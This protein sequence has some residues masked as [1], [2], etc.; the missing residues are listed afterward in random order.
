MAGLSDRLKAL[1]VRIG[2][3]DLPKPAPR[4]TYPVEEMVQ[5]RFEISP[6][7]QTFVAEAEH[8][9]GARHGRVSL[10][11][12]TSLNGI[13][14]WMPDS[15]LAAGEPSGI[16]FLDTET[17]GLGRG[18]GTYAFLVGLGRY[19][20]R[21]LYVTQLFMRDPAEELAL[22]TTL[23]TYLAGES[24]TLVTFNGLGF[25]VPLLNVRYVTNAEPSPLPLMGHLDLLP[26]ARR[27]WSERLSSRS[28]SSLE[29]HILGFSRTQDDVPGWMIPQ[30]YFDYLRTGDARPLTNVFYHNAMDILS[31]AALLT[32]VTALLQEPLSEHVDGRDLVALGRLCEAQRRAEAAIQ[33]YQCGIAHKRNSNWEEAIALWKIAAAQG[34]TYAHIELAKFYEHKERSY[35]EAIRWTEAAIE[36]VSSQSSS[37]D[38]R[39]QQLAELEHRLNRL[40]GKLSRRG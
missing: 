27:L 23:D 31:M 17:T 18:T 11:S 9:L 35:G 29:Q 4:S 16:V 33:L 39:D 20:P 26:L 37:G 8:P 10:G 34:R 30:L 19:T 2:A 38:S 21:S 15:D 22:L 40:T 1:G 24:R 14:E 12:A 32:H 5:G 36:L 28:L 25:D 7:G 3:R 13:A 6:Y